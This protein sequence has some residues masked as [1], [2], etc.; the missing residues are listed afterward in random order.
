MKALVVLLPTD[1]VDVDSLSMQL[2]DYLIDVL[3]IESK[4]ITF[5]SEEIAQLLIKNRIE[6]EN[7]K[8]TIIVDPIL[9][10]IEDIVRELPNSNNLESFGTTESTV[11]VSDLVFRYLSDKN[12]HSYMIQNRSYIRDFLYDERVIKNTKNS[13]KYIKLRAIL[14]PALESIHFFD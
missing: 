13:K 4:I 5:Q 11:W 7:K 1:N 10:I 14:K 6:A 9:I 12:F 2:G 8:E 3:Q